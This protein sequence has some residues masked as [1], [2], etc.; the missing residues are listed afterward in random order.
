MGRSSGGITGITSRIIQSGR[1][2]ERRKADVTR[3]RLTARLWRWPLAVSITCLSSS[4][5]ASRSTCMSSSRTASAPV[6]PLKY[7]PKLS[8]SKPASRPNMRSICR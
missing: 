4:A 5:S 6:P 1:L 2:P 3:R 8:G 7:T